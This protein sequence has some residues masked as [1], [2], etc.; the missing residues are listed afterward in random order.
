LSVSCMFVMACLVCY[1][2]TT[3]HLLRLLLNFSPMQELL[4]I[5]HNT[6]ERGLLTGTTVELQHLHAS[7]TKSPQQLI[8]E[9][10]T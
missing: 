6:T 1:H 7:E 2:S 3:R 4:S 10:K 9:A 5:G 8:L